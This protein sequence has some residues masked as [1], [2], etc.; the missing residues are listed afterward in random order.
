MIMIPQGIW[1]QLSY[2]VKI[3]DKSFLVAKFF[4]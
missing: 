3:F 1:E 4:I 2:N